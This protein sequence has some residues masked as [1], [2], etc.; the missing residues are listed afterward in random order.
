MSAQYTAQWTL[1]SS[2]AAW[3]T[4]IV[5]LG[6]VAGTA[7][8]ALLNVADIV[9]ARVLF[10]CCA[11]VG[12]VANTMLLT[13]DGLSGA[14]VWRFVTGLAITSVLSAVLLVWRELTIDE[15]IIDFRILKS[16]QVA[17]GVMFAT[18]LGLALY[19]SVFVLP[20]FLQQL[21]GYSL[22]DVTIKT[23]RT[24]QIRVHLASK[25]TP[26]LGDP[27]YGSGAP[28]APLR[29]ALEE[30]GLTRQALHAAVLGFVHPVTGETLRF[31]S[32]LPPDMA[33]LET[34]LANI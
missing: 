26:C 27:V 21:H 20:V 5:Q 14:L 15:P 16:R 8:S 6:F 19:G 13:A 10:A 9:P 17:P 4:T 25:G 1:S 7:V 3:L 29:A 2:E 23:G 11:M 24:H 34:L 18:F 31:E 32:P 30:A 22:L 28:A 12:A 33:R